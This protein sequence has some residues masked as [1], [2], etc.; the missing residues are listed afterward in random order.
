VSEAKPYLGRCK[1]C[2]Y[3]LF[4]TAEDIQEASSLRDVTPG[5]AYRVGN[6]ILSR[7]DKRHKVFQLKK[8]KGTYSKDHKCDSRC[9]NAKG[10]DCTCACGGMNHGRG[11]AIA[12]TTAHSAPQV[13]MATD[14]QIAFIKVLIEKKLDDDAYNR[15]HDR[16]DKGLTLELASAW[17]AKL[18]DMP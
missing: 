16:L 4:T 18:K 13:R 10:H 12:V 3:A 1:E 8:I 14:K 7:C 11:H 9:L 2:D 5:V 17:I 15:A 6:T